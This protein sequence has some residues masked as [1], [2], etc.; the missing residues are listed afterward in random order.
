MQMRFAFRVLLILVFCLG[1]AGLFAPEISFSGPQTSAPSPVQTPLPAP[2][3][4]P[5]P[6]PT[7]TPVVPLPSPEAA[8]AQTPSPEAS[9]EASPE[10]SETPVRQIDKVA[11]HQALI[12]LNSTWTIMCVAAHPDDEDG[13][14]L[15]VLRRKYGVHT[16]SLFSTYGEG[17]QNAVGPE[18][19]EE[20]GVIRARETLAASEIQGSVPH[21]LGL[22]DFG[23]SKSA[24][25]T[26]KVWGEEEA[27]RRMV[28]KIREL[29]PDVIITN[30][31]TSRG[32]GHHQATG[33]LILE[34]FDA[35]ADP[36]R[37]PEQLQRE[38][39]WQPARLFVRYRPPGAAPSPTPGTP[40]SSLSPT[41][42]AMPAPSQ[43][44]AATP[45]P[46]PTVVAPSTAT[47][48]PA[49]KVVAID[50][51]EVDPVR[52]T[53]YAEQA[54]AA[55]HMHATQ[56]PWPKTIAERLAS[57]GNPSSGLPLIR[58]Q[59]VKEAPGAPPLP[60]DAK[61]FLDGLALEESV[62]SQLRPPRIEDRS[63]IEFIDMPDRV[64]NALIH[65]RR[66]QAR[67]PEVGTGQ[68]H[69][70]RLLHTRGNRALAVASGISLAVASRD[71][72]LVPNTRSTFTVNLSNLG[73]RTVEIER[74]SFLGWG[75][76]VRLDAAEFLT[77]D[78]DT[79]SRVDL[80]TPPNASLTV[81]NAD[82]LYDGRFE[83]ETFSTTADLELDGA[84]FSVVAETNLP[85]TPPVE[86]KSLSPPVVVWTPGTLGQPWTLQAKLANNLA[87]PFAGHAEIKGPADSTFYAE[88]EIQ[89]QPH[90]ER[91]IQF[92]GDNRPSE[93]MAQSQ[94]HSSPPSTE[95]AQSQLQSGTVS[96][97]I[98]SKEAVASRHL[99]SVYTDARVVRGLRVG[100]LP[101]FDKTLAQSL[102]A[103]GITATEL[104]VEAIQNGQLGEYDTI[105]IDNRGYQAHPELI[106]ANSKL[107]ERVRA[108]AT[109]IVFYHK[110]DEW[111]PDEK[112]NRPQLA[113]YPI[114]L[115][116]DR[117]TEE[118][119]PI[120]FLMPAH[121]LMNVP[122]RIKS[123][124]FDGWIQERG[125]YYPKEWDRRYQ[126]LFAS[127]DQGEEPLS[128][129]L[130]VA[131]LG[132][133][134]YI[135]TSMVWYRQLAAGVPGAYR[136]FANMI[137]YGHKPRNPRNN[138]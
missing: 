129:G 38:T 116:G 133:G 28:Q 17:G 114:I 84:R 41:V 30:H 100:Y 121:A 36:K 131:R 46:S 7:A 33:R 109:L 68:S 34:A 96:F 87:T 51:N 81:P 37:F 98:G 52:G 21:F 55:L 60:A 43:T 123:S 99:R 1:L 47:T 8:P 86:I 73:E 32:H 93:E 56:G 108:G 132:R 64:L 35:A 59:L 5:S 95:M 50:P 74:L 16:V 13:T 67:S 94:S 12:D 22:R 120:K 130:L 48:P 92:T 44:N 27:L 83:G 137:S 138:K 70:A 119:A 113:P 23:F 53:M 88:P 18:L 103:L 91:D 25:E 104:T 111:N 65:W 39:V 126:A 102:S 122:N 75:A 117:V 90:E 29:R 76:G 61:R 26:F 40:T 124:D 54:L 58:Y 82:H 97:S 128:G 110:N 101:S 31:D 89:L 79:I 14:T 127:A 45:A 106:A 134:N 63:L 105:I 135:Y 72:V 77:T 4:T 80:V 112:K 20:L 71:P 69:R 118:D 66:S 78:T 9:P 19:Y 15:T 136:M 62:K 6:T 85:V 125:L 57:L 42:A 24:E 11:L 49:E 2:V 3:Q 115:S 107:L 10:P